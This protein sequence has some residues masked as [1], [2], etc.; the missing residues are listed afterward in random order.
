MVQEHADVPLIGSVAPPALHVMTFNIRRR[1]NGLAWRRADRWR[2]RAPAVRALLRQEQPTIAGLQEVMPD[3]ADTVLVSLGRRYRFVGRGHGRRG[4][5]E[6]CPLFYDAERLELLDWEQTALSEYPHEAGSRS[7]GN[8]IPRIA[9]T[10]RFRDR[11]TGGRFAAVNTH[12]DPFSARS[13]VRSADALKA[14]IGSAPTVLT[15]DLNAGAGSRTLREMLDGGL[16]DAWSV[17]EHRATAS[18]GTFANYRTPRPDRAR[19]DWILVTRDVMVQQAAINARLFAG[20]WASDHLPVQAVLTLP[21]E[22]EQR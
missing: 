21:D 22:Q 7:W 11:A 8:M 13:R 1:M 3:Q 4:T 19:I 14:I 20:V 17:A 5:G 15:G 2:H 12:L 16:R 9:V 6:A 10:A 18:V